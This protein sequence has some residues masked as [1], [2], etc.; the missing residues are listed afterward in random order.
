[1]GIRMDAGLALSAL[2]LSIWSALRAR[3]QSRYP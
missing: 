2:F 3:K 1:V